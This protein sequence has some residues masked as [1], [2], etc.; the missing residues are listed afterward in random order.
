MRHLFLLTALFC[1]CLTS[2]EG[3]EDKGKPDDTPKAA[4]T[5]KLLKQKISVEITDSR[6]EEA[7]DEL[8]EQVKGL[9]IILDSKGGV[10]RNQKVSYTGKDQTVEEVLDGLLKKN[11]LGYIVISKTGD[12][13]DGLVQ[14]RQGKERGYPL[15]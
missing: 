12:A 7:M 4:A 15:K 14:I 6:L 5:R 8:K 11:G 13:Y 10:S 9:K 1:L 2:G 3:A